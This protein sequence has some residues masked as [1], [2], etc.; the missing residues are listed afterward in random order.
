MGLM[1][2]GAGYIGSRLN[3][4]LDF[5]VYDVGYFG[6]FRDDRNGKRNSEYD[7]IIWLAAYASNWLCEE[8]PVSSFETNV[9]EFQALCQNLRPHQTLIYAS[10]A[11]VYGQNP[12]VSIESDMPA[13]ALMN[14]DLQKLICDQIASKYI[15]QG[16]NIIGLRF[17]TVNGISP[18]TRTDLMVNSMVQSAMKEGRIYVSNLERRRA[19]LFIEDLVTAF[20]LILA[21][22]KA[23]IYNLHSINTRVEGLGE[24][25]CQLLD[26]HMVIN[27]DSPNPYDFHMSS[28]LFIDTFGWFQKDNIV[29][30]VDGLL[31]GLSY[32]DLS[33]RD[34]LPRD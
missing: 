14:Y 26:C 30:V 11:S 7:T 16:K 9:G 27:P 3:Q 22:P 24:V 12:G 13:E 25:I 19:L 31:S 20:E 1:I 33:R 4:T 10:S 34:E 17:G 28:Q 2:G 29:D 32:A 21:R 23:G 8:M 15:R 6:R 18:H 5:D